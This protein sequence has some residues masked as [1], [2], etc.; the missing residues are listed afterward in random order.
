MTNKT[1]RAKKAKDD[2]TPDAPGATKFLAYWK[3]V[4]TIGGG[5]ASLVTGCLSLFIGIPFALGTLAVCG[6]ILWMLMAR[7]QAAGLF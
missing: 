5:C 7:L 1:A 6:Y 2:T 4:S 3:I